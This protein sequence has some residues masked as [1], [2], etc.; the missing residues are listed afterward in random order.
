MKSILELK[1]GE[2][3]LTHFCSGHEGATKDHAS[4]S[5]RPCF[6]LVAGEVLGPFQHERGT[7]EQGTKSP[8]AQIGSEIFKAIKLQLIN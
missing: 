7:L 2:K 1:D 5:Y 4:N 8:N 3:S 6:K